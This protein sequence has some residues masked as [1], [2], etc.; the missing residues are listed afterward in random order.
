[1]VTRRKDSLSAS[2]EDYL[3]AIA[4]LKEKGGVARVKNI[5]QMLNVKNPSVNAA[6]NALADAGLVV[7][8][9]YGYADLTKEGEAA[10]RKV[11]DRHEVLL[12]FLTTV[13]DMDN[14]SAEYDACR[15]E[16]SIGDD[17]FRRLNRLMDFI[18][19]GN[20]EKNGPEWLVRFHEY[21]NADK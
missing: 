14:T 13:L 11:I 21:L 10:A 4:V 18:V 15:M 7:H 12:R 2:M 3:E 19:D 1:M 9:R 6:L 20:R 16:H 5:G 17:G 8:E